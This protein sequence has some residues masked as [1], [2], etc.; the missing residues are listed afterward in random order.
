MKRRERD[1]EEA[2]RAKDAAL[3]D[4]SALLEAIEHGVL[5]LDADLTIRLTNRAYREIWE[6]PAEFYDTP[7][8][9][10]EDMR[11]RWANGLYALSREEFE[12]YI[13]AREAA[14]LAGTEPMRE[15]RLPNGKVIQ[16]RIIPLPDGGWM[17]SYLDISALKQIE[18]A[19]REAK[20][21]AEAANVA[22]SQFLANMSHEVRTPLH[23]VLGYTQ[24]ILDG[25]Y[26]EIPPEAKDPL[27]RI[28]VNGNHLLSLINDIL[29]FSK[30][31]AGEFRLARA[32]VPVGDILHAAAAAA[33]SLARGKGLGLTVEV[34]DRLP[35]VV[36]D[37][38][39]LT[40]VLL[41]LVGNAVKFTDRGSIAIRA[42]AASA[43][44]SIAVEDTGIGI[45]EE[46]RTRIFESFQQGA[47]AEPRA[48][49]GTGLGLAISKRIIEMHGGSISVA[50]E[51]GR[52]STFTIVL[53]VAPLRHERP[54]G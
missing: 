27:V 47:N 6:I 2:N 31:E 22:K 40:Q 12:A 43:G 13:A 23:A 50:S 15:R 16:S 39:R 8:R 11:R 49:A 25:L 24:M 29:D 28:G 5:F 21:H 48:E 54:D 3:H 38:R 17:L 36:G 7:R 18:D 41:N 14:I 45:P 20:G 35:Q 30:I 51:V 33:E 32:P 34:P 44:I 52:G 4:L 19:L 10:A 26:G 9:L 53:P 42:A 46:E 1:L 37:E